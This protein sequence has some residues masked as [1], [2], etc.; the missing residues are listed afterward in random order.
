MLNLKREALYDA[1]MSTNDKI[2]TISFIKKDGTERVMNCRLGVTSYLAGGKATVKNDGKPYV[3]VFDMH[4]K[5][6]RCINIETAKTF[7]AEGAVFKI[8]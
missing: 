8:I 2:F 5:G 7:K 4:S 1:I 3:I 6:Y